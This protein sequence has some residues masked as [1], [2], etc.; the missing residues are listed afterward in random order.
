MSFEGG[1]W[2]AGVL[3]AKVEGCEEVFSLVHQRK[4]DNGNDV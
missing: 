1:R 4:E 3:E 2:T